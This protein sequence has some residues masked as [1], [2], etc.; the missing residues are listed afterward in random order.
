MGSVDTDNQE[1][2]AA[3][4]GGGLLARAGLVLLLLIFVGAAYLWFSRERIA[5]DLIDDYLTETGLEAT[6]DIVSIGPQR[7]VIANVVVGDPDA[8]DLTID[9]VSVD[10]SYGIT[11]TG[12]GSVVLDNP[13]V[14]GSFSDGAL[15]FGAL[16]AILFSESDTDAAGLPALDV[17][18]RNG[19]ARLETDF[20]EIGA[21]LEGA[22]PLD[23]GFA[24]KLALVAPQ[25][26]VEGCAAGRTTAYGDLTIEDGA[27][28]FEGPVR[29]RD[30]ACEGATLASADIATQLSTDADFAKVEGK[31][32]LAT[33]ALGYADIAAD[34][35]RGRASFA[36]AQETFVLDHDIT[37]DGLGNDYASIASLRADGAVRS[38][39]GFTESSWNAAF[40][41]EDIAL[42]GA[43]EG[44]LN[45]AIQASEGTLIAP[46]LTKLQSGLASATRQA[47]LR[48][49]V[50]ARQ[51]GEAL[52]L[53]VPEAR[54]SSASGETVLALSRLTWSR[55]NAASAARLS[56]NILTGGADLPQI[57]G[58][59]EQAGSA[60]F[61]ARF[62]VAPFIAGEDRLAIPS[63][64]VR[65]LAGGGFA[66][67]GAAR[68]SGAIPG[69][70]IKSLEV[71]INGTISARG[72]V[73]AGLACE[74][75][76]FEALVAYDLS[77]EAKNLEICPGEAN[78]MIAYGDSLAVNVVTDALALNGDLSGSPLGL[79]ASG[80]RLSYPG[81]FE[82]ADVTGVIGEPD[83]AVRFTSASLT[84][85]FDEAI[86]GEFAG[87]TAQLDVVPLDLSELAGRWSYVDS[88][89]NVTDA[90][91]TLTERPQDGLTPRFNPLSSRG[92]SLTL[93]GNDIAVLTSLDHKATGTPI[94]NVQIAH[95]LSS[96]EGSALIDVDALNFGSPLSVAD[97]SDLARGVI[98][99][100]QGTVTGEGRVAWTS[101]DITSSGTFRTDNLDLA[102]AFGPVSGLKGELRFTDLLNLT[103]APG[104]VIEIGSI[105]PGIEVLA[106]KVRFSLTNG[107]IV[108]VEDARW[109][110]MGGELMMRPTTLLYG[111]D[112]GQSYVFEITALDAATFVSQM[113]LSNIGATGRFDGTVGIT[114]DSRG[115][116]TIDQGLLISRAPGGNV[117][118]VGEL[119]Y[120]D[121]GA[122]SNYAFQALRSMDYKQMSVG[123][124][125]DL[126]G[127]IIT[128]FT[129]DG[130]RQGD[131]A[132]QDFITRRLAKLPIRF[133]I[134]VR[135]E[136]F[137]ELATMVRTFWDPE[138]LPDAIESG[139]LTPEGLRA[140]Q[141][142]LPTRVIEPDP[143]SPSPRPSSDTD[144]SASDAL[145]PRS[146][147]STPAGSVQPLESEN[148]P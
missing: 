12:I 113:E 73:R 7:Q 121:M 8:P 84:G 58:R 123:L 133:K 112:N 13:R 10:V 90:R 108:E 9:R 136:N 116:G 6:Y 20:G 132:N 71:P 16:D 39:R 76:R 85:G 44:A 48:G 111:T 89:L 97:L 105:N 101:D 57:T 51:E 37:V 145:R 104:Q 99:Y 125:G 95:N 130:V 110:F 24:G 52:S 124:D 138:A 4:R 50:T 3:S 60:P 38:G 2:E 77:L 83:N 63:F 61:S 94:T 131:D 103:T 115:N 96:G 74:T 122:I 114:F 69:G 55:A 137:Y 27:P 141:G 98:A 118:Y 117:S 40:E 65:G 128:R 43:S 142:G 139:A 72:N 5:G 19:G 59:I 119:T 29:L 42:V 35:L 86:A 17:T 62:S 64:S 70:V 100:T 23:D 22:G 15:S 143:S 126:A 1:P 36:L 102:A 91:F 56:G 45:D 106:G 146:S 54:L 67:S 21:F 41:G 53:V 30:V 18:I 26:G 92:A 49:D 93:N 25:I 148:L 134:N 80:A 75:V 34:G 127:E 33:S 147:G 32:D 109:P 144:E 11:S 28:G 135:S 66:F 68:A 82:L 14:Y 140:G 107:E 81:G 78:A 88:V 46:L 120:E 47:S 79:S 87:A 31:L 129:F